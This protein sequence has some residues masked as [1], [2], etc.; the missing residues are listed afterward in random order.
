MYNYRAV[1][2]NYFALLGIPLVRGRVFTEDDRENNLP[3]V[4]INEAA[5]HRFWPAADPVGQRI[6]WASDIPAFD[7]TKLTV[8]GIVADVKS[9]GLDKPEAPA[10]YAPYTQRVFPWL[11]WNSFVV[12]THGD[13]TT[14]ERIIR[15]ELT[16]VD[17]MQP[18]Y[19]VASLDAVIAQ[20]VAAQRF[21]TS[22]IDLF[23]ALAL[24]LCSIG[25]YGTINH[26]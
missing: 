17:P 25:V 20:S 8:V 12:R 10:I 6:S 1:S 16:R 3:V 13:P 5:A 18:I 19:Q 9:N 4:V 2:A 7:S 24:A 15:E 22:L 21:H 14:Y 23:A 26:W 11:R